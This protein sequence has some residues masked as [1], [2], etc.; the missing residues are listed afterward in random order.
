MLSKELNLLISAIVFALVVAIDF[1][2][3]PAFMDQ[4]IIATKALRKLPAFFNYWFWVYSV[5]LFKLIPILAHLC[6]YVMKDKSEA[7][8][9]FLVAA[10]DNTMANVIRLMYH[11]PRPCFVDEEIADI[12]CVCSFGNP[13]GHA[14]SSVVLYTTLYYLL[15]HKDPG[16]CDRVKNICTQLLLFVLVN[17]GLSRVYFGE[18]FINQVLMGW[19]LGY[20]ILSLFYYLYK[21]DTFD[22][23]VLRTEPS[24]KTKSRN[25]IL[26][27]LIAVFSVI[28]ISALAGWYVTR[29]YYESGPSHPLINTPCA[30]KCLGPDK[31]LSDT[32]VANAG[33]YSSAMYLLLGFY[34]YGKGVGVYNSR[35]YSRAFNSIG[36][37]IKRLAVY[38]VVGSPLVVGVI[39]LQNPGPYTWLLMNFCCLAFTVLFMCAMKPL[40]GWLRV[41][42]AG[43]YFE[44][45]ENWMDE[46]KEE[47]PTDAFELGSAA[48]KDVLGA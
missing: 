7:V 11:D 37:V 21:L 13:S 17:I 32:N 31:F 39:L 23:V 10:A 24:P 29:Q 36:N 9:V 18:H 27:A 44:A 12:G 33:L 1:T 28:Q 48:K 46:E 34:I 43:D 14:S 42:V 47:Q 41:S 35:Y 2:F 8:L 26:L 22:I 25:A 40:L 30:G 16:T 19:S 3:K 45:D 38:G 20:L 6:L 5:P 15:I 4:S